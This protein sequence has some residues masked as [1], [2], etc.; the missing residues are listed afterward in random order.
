MRLLGAMIFVKDLPRMAAFYETSLGLQPI[1]ETR[2]DAW[3]EF[4]AG[5]SRF[6][7]HAIPASIAAEI[8][9][10]SPPQP[11]ERNPVKL[12]FEIEDLDAEI[13][14]LTALGVAIFHRPWGT[15]D[16]MDPE[17]N[18]FQITSSNDAQ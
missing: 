14:R 3:V 18:I 6:A 11:R 1:Q 17:G 16:G 5:G 13:R 15:V 12:T 4:D 9:I 10:A 8:E 7:L 2:M